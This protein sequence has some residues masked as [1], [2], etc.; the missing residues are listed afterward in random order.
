MTQLTEMATIFMEK[1]GNYTV[2]SP[3]RATT[4]RNIIQY[5][6]NATAIALLMALRN[7]YSIDVLFWEPETIWLTVE[8]DGIP[9]DNL[10][11]EKIQAAI[12]LL[13]NPAFFWDN[14][15]FQRTVQALNGV[16]YDP[17]AL[18]ECGVPEMCWAV[19]EATLLRTLDPDDKAIPEFDEDVQQYIA[20]CLK[21]AG[22][23]YPPDQLIFAADNLQK[24]LPPEAA[25][26]ST[27]V[28][29]SWE[30]IPKDTLRD[31]KFSE[32]ALGVQ[33]SKLAACY[34]FVSQNVESMAGNVMDM[35]KEVTI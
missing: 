26:F 6:E 8:K 33:L 32:D 23:V 30:H 31:R 4:A 28:K 27:R 29:N 9:I 35:E 21:N 16:P 18:Q 15:L 5:S 22:Y 25:A 2:K 11:R 24:M 3:E 17:Q 14:L 7:L 13:I 10:D 19:Y 1:I 12:T 34:I 20:V